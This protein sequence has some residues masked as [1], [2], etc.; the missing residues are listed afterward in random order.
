M[1]EYQQRMMTLQAAFASHQNELAEAEAA[2]TE[3]IFMRMLEIVQ[4]YARENSC[5]LVLEKSSVLYAA[6]TQMEFTDALV[7]RYNAAH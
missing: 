7:E 5:A 3:R 2:A 4:A 6:D 1:Q